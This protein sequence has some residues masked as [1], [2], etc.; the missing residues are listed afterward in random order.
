M[1]RKIMKIGTRR[2][3]GRIVAALKQARRTRDELAGRALT[4]GARGAEQLMSEQG[5]DGQEEYGCHVARG[6]GILFGGSSTAA[7]AGAR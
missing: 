4:S 1:N 3:F 7:T 6:L 5:K 2:H